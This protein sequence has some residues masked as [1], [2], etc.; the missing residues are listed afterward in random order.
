MIKRLDTRKPNAADFRIMEQLQQSPEEWREMERKRATR[1]QA[2]DE[3]A[4]RHLDYVNI[5]QEKAFARIDAIEA[6]DLTP[7][8]ALKW[9]ET[10]VKLERLIYK[11]PDKYAHR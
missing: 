9:L 6:K 4:R 5:L 8:E 11:L 3:M 1:E 7:S 2:I 10:S